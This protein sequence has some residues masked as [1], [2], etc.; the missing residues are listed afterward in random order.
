MRALWLITL[1]ALLNYAVLIWIGTTQLV[2]MTAG[3]QPLDLRVTGYSHGDVLAYVAVLDRASIELL[4][5]LRWVDTSFPM[6]FALA[7]IGWGRRWAVGF[8][9][10]IRGLA[11]ILPLA[12]FLADMAE[13]T[14][15]ARIFTKAMPSIEL[16][17]M[18]STLTIVKFIAVAL[19]VLLLMGLGYRVAVRKD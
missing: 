8:P 5:T 14:V 6:L 18:A 4:T 19:A 11:V 2:P 1:A 15:V 3:L 13:N 10:H 9:L 7:L 17:Q 12:Y 16:V